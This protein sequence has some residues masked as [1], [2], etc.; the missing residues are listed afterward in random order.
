MISDVTGILLAGGQSRR[1]GKDKR[2]LYVGEDTLL[3]RSENVLRSVFSSVCIVIAQDSPPLEA[4][5]PVVRDLVPGCGSLGGLFTG[6]KMSST[7]FVFLAACDMP[8]LEST[9]IEYLVSKKDGADVVMVRTEEGMQTTHAVYSKKCIPIIEEMLRRGNLKI[10]ELVRDHSLRVRLIEKSEIQGDHHF[11]KSFINVNTPTD[12]ERAQG[13][14][15]EE[16]PKD[17]VADQ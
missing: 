11:T 1:M 9:L 7:E 17:K 10:Q 4:E 14:H 13:I 2:F 5:I 16:S 8:F 6:L 3:T 12:L 15:I